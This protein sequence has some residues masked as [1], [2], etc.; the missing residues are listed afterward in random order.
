[1][2][3]VFVIDDEPLLER[4]YGRLFRTSA[5]QHEFLLIPPQWDLI[6]LTD[7]ILSCE[8]R[9]V[10]LDNTWHHVADS[11]ICT[12]VTLR[13]CGL[14]GRVA[15]VSGEPRYEIVQSIQ[16]HGGAA[17]NIDVIQKPW[18]ADALVRYVRGGSYDQ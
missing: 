9:V 4:A 14:R 7:R 8:P 1:M 3:D 15:I 18:A 5:L 10:L 6:A 12:A 17:R 2:I 13:L 11:G 16:N